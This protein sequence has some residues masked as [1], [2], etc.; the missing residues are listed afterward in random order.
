MEPFLTG[1]ILEKRHRH[2]NAVAADISVRLGDRAPP[3]AQSAKTE[4]VAASPRQQIATAAQLRR[5]LQAGQAE[6]DDTL[7]RLELSPDV[8]YKLL[9]AEIAAQRGDWKTAYVASM[10][11]AQQTRDPRL[12]QRA[13]EVALTARRHEETLSAIRLWRTLAPDSEQATQYFLGFVMLSDN[14]AEAGPIFAQKLKDIPAASRTTLMF[15]IQRLLARA[16][17]KPAG[18]AMLEQ[19]L[20]P[21]L[22]TPETRLVLAQGALAAGD[23]PRARQEALAAQAAK[24]DSELAALAVAQV[25]ADKAEASKSL[26]AYLAKY[27]KARE[28]RLALARLLIE[29][30]RHLEARGQF[31]LLLKEDRRT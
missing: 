28:V 6:S 12:A 1:P 26:A 29:Q 16:K 24:P 14:L 23:V 4:T 10:A 25:T 7:P 2:C 17:D 15:Q 11:M 8:L 22:G 5:M 31:E 18:F 30:K 3:A 9:A 21:Y 13:M 27:P 20:T 19:V